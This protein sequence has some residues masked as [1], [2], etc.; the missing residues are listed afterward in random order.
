M[1]IMKKTYQNPTLEVV[2]LQTVGML[3]SSVEGFNSTLN[4]EK[5]IG[6]SDMLGRDSDFEE[7]D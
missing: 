5:S 4:S 2:K 3:A 6:S 7:E 1:K